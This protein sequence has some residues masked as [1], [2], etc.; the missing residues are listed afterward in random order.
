MVTKRVRFPQIAFTIALSFLATSGL[1]LSSCAGPRVEEKDAEIQ[2]LQS[3]VQSIQQELDVERRKLQE[4][5]LKLRTLQPPLEGKAVPVRELVALPDEYLHKE[6]LV[7]GRL[8]AEA[9]VR[10]PVGYFVL[11]ALD[12]NQVIQC[13]FK[14]QDLDPNSRR[15]LTAKQPYTKMRVLG[16]LTRTSDGLASEIGI[17]PNSGYEFHVLKIED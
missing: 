15:L 14:L 6:V 7:E 12:S 5:T 2:A 1:V 13:Y 16:R 3:Q 17:R 4:L 11:S 9:L 8:V 10:D